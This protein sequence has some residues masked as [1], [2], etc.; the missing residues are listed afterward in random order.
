[1]EWAR[2]VR[3]G[4]PLETSVLAV[5]T[6]VLGAGCLATAAFPM[7]EDSPRGVILGIGLAALCV[8]FAVLRAGPRVRRPHLHVVVVLFIALRGVMVALAT[9]E[10]GLMLAALGYTWTAV[11]ATFF[12]SATAAWTYAA[13][14]TVALGASMLVA[15]APTDG[16][17]WVTI[18]TMV[19]VAVAILT[20]LNAR[21]RAQAH[22]DSLTGLLNRAGF[23]LAA[24][25]QRAM[26]RR[27]GEPVSLALIDLD[28][29]KLVNDRRG[30][31]AG[32]R[33][34]VELGQA[35]TAALRPGDLL[36]RFGGD[37]FVLLMPGVGADQAPKVLARL[38]QAHPTAWTAGTVVCDDDE[39]L[40]EAV[41]R[42]DQG[43]YLA[44]RSRHA[45]DDHRARATRTLQPG[46]A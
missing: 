3:K 45:G 8:A 31:R 44:R 37:E 39:P 28:G 20:R 24:N 4:T 17:V 18:C 34:L 43:L 5:V 6:L 19:W 22:T 35:W 9:T 16:V 41:D 38:E 42:A 12:F 23:S 46:R 13:L 36:A 10:R 29:F 21:L 2:L 11:Y 7:A 32:D 1:M 40:D 14:M 26:S 33:L 25:R 15:T 30:H 27:R